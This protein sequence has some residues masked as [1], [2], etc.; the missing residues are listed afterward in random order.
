MKFSKIKTFKYFN[1]QAPSLFCKLRGQWLLFQM[2]SERKKL[3]LY[4]ILCT[5]LSSLMIL[6]LGCFISSQA[7]GKL[8]CLLKIT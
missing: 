6:I 7:P 3:T 5:V 4:I 1:P 2:L 8:N